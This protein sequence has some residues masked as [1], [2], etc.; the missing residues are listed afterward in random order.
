MRY[1]KESGVR[2]KGDCDEIGT[3]DDG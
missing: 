1:D 3:Q 2:V